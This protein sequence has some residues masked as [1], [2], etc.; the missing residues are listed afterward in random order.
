MVETTRKLVQLPGLIPHICLPDFSVAAAANSSYV[1]DKFR[2]S[3]HEAQVH[4]CQPTVLLTG[5]DSSCSM[6]MSHAVLTW[7]DFGYLRVQA[8]LQ[9]QN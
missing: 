6:C 5:H 2:E 4:L 7:P 1:Y 8:P 9:L 3:S